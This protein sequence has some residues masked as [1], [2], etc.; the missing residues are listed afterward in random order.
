MTKD[1]YTIADAP[2]WQQKALSTGLEA[3]KQRARGNAQ[4]R[5]Y[6]VTETA[7]GIT[8]R[9]HACSEV[10]ALTIGGNMIAARK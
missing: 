5:A 2:E 1:A 7:T 8:Q 9:V 10:E 4:V 3:R 6:I